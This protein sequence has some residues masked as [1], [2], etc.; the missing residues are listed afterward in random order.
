[1][2]DGRNNCVHPSANPP[3][4]ADVEELIKKV[5]GFL[6]SFPVFDV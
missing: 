6:S 1:M 4:K 5:G 3:G 2:G